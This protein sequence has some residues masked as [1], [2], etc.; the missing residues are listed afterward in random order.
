MIDIQ[1][2]KNKVERHRDAILSKIKRLRR[3]DPFL[4]TDRALIVEPG[5]DAA[6]LFGHEQVAI[7][8]TRLKD[9]LGEIE[10][11]LT[12]IKKGTYGICERC[13]KRI[14]LARLEVKPSAIYCLKCKEEIEKGKKI[15]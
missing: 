5:S 10:R 9:E 13:T 15:K 6:A 4:T 1:K 8:E 12:K 7:M 3:E 14:E 2:I 11:A